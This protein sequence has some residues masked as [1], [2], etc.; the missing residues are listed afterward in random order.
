MKKKL[1]YY[2]DCFINC[3]NLPYHIAHHLIGPNHTP[4]HRKVV[5]VM[6]MVL[7]GTIMSVVTAISHSAV[8]HVVAD[9]IGNGI[10]GIGLIP[11]IK[12][13]EKKI[14]NTIS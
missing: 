8:S 13:V 3:I 1:L 9:V 12:D 2:I 4:T 10:H 5:G 11:F 14:E 7:G 6:V